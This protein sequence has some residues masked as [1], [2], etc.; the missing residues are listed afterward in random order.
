MLTSLVRLLATTALLLPLATTAQTL[1][2]SPDGRFT[3]QV[4]TGWQIKPEPNLS[5][6]TFRN[7]AISV[8]VLASQRH[9]SNATVICV[10]GMNLDV[11]VESIE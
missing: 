9:K 6:V 2:A 1:Y 11:A 7:G 10:A 5:L 8:S 3:I 4:P